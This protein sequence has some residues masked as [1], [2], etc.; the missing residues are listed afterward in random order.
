MLKFFRLRFFWGLTNSIEED[1]MF[2]C[3][4]FIEDPEFEMLLALL[5][6]TNMT[7]SDIASKAEKAFSFIGKEFNFSLNLIR[8]WENNIWIMAEEMELP[9][10]R[11]K[12]YSGWVRNSSSVGTK[13]KSSFSI[14][15]GLSEE[16]SEDNFNEFNFLYSLISVGSYEANTGMVIRLP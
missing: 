16:F 13:S 4:E 15:E 11:H 3:P 10:T 12:A 6:N 2:N 7:R 8:Q 9:I 5:A 1:L 14:P